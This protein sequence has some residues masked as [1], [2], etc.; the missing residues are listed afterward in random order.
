M[1]PVISQVEVSKYE[2]AVIYLR[3]KGFAY[4]SKSLAT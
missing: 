3:C 4:A 1:K 2:F